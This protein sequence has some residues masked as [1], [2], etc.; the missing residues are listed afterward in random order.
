MEPERKPAQV[1]QLLQEAQS[2][3][4]GAAAEL[5]PLVYDELR[6]LAASFFGTPNPQH[7]LQPTAL[8]HEAYLKLVNVPDRRW[9]G[10]RHFFEVAAKALRQ[11]LINH[12][13][14][15]RA[16]KRGGDAAAHRITLQGDVADSAPQVLD[17]L[18]LEEALEDLERIDP[19]QCRVVELRYFAGMSVE[20][21][22]QVLGISERTVKR[23]WRMAKAELKL[24]LA[25]NSSSG[26]QDV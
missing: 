4:T 1:T 22:A 9:D 19:M 23:E 18:A 15:K 25:G 12:A 20:E 2:G 6:A 11:I 3:R 21:T 13:R 5:L 7:T 26:G 24:R 10:R 14:D 8:V 17:M 16:Q